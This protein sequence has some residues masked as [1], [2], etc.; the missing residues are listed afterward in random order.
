MNQIFKNDTTNKADE[1]KRALSVPIRNGKSLETSLYA[2]LANQ[3]LEVTS[4]HYNT[5]LRG[6]WGVHEPIYLYD[7]V[8][9]KGTPFLKY[10]Y[11]RVSTITAK[12]ITEGE[13]SYIELE[14]RTNLEE[15]FIDIY[16]LF[17]ATFADVIYNR[18]IQLYDFYIED[19]DPEK[20][21]FSIN[22]LKTM[23]FFFYKSE[24]RKVPS[25]TIDDSGNFHCTWKKGNNTTFILAF[26]P[27]RCAEFLYSIRAS[28]TF[29]IPFHKSGYGHIDEIVI[30]EIQ[31]NVFEELLY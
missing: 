9:N 25:I 18:L 14:K 30:S 23:L 24:T 7:K 10:E 4:Y 3:E 31:K 6:D 27:N 22:S 21:D 29:P 13:A 16:G 26:F 15:V 5:D 28:E 1:E 19:E 12:E 2:G 11:K 20:A 8:E 17:N